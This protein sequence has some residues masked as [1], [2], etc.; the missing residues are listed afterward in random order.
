M[1]I[2]SSILLL[3]LF[4][5]STTDSRNGITIFSTCY[6]ANTI[7]IIMLLGFP[8]NE[9]FFMVCFSFAEGPLAGH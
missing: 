5:G 7:F 9:R 6:Y 8:T 4:D 3:F 2:V 1:F